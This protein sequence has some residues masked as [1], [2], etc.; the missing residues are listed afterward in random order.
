MKIIFGGVRGTSSIAQTEYMRYGGET[1]SVLVEGQ[2]GERIILDAGTGIRALG[3]RLIQ[4]GVEEVL[5]LLSHYHLDHVVGWPSF[6]LLYRKG[7]TVRVASSH[8]DGVEAEQILSQLMN[9]PFWPVQMDSVQARLQFESTP[10][11]YGH[12]AIRSCPVHHPGGCAAYRVD[13]PASGTS[14]VFATD[15]EWS[16]STESEKKAFIQLCKEPTPCGWLLFDGQYSRATY[17][18][19]IGWGHSCWEDAVAVARVCETK[20]LRIIHHAPDQKDHQLERIRRRVMAAHS[21]ADLALDGLEV[22]L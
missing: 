15:I 2:A 6:P 12:L 20:K 14:V 13:E 16:Q 5:L 4:A 18:S 11:Q 7:V 19:Y 10:D 8:K 1:T 17:P 3:R 22:D 21:G 9:Q